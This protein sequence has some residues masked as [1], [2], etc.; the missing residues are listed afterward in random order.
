MV[1][2]M[3]SQKKKWFFPKLVEVVYIKSE[4]SIYS[5]VLLT[6]TNVS[7]SYLLKSFPLRRNKLPLISNICT[8]YIP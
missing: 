8:V 5:A 6:N 4:T 1:K 7:D 2:N 3:D